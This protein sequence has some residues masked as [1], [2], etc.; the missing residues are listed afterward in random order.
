MS[1]VKSYTDYAS[2]LT[3]A[4]PLFHTWMGIAMLSTALG[5]GC[6]VC[7]WGR[8]VCPNVWIVLLAQSGIL[9]KTT[10][11]NIGEDVLLD[12]GA[13][14]AD[15]IW[16]AEWSFEG[17]LSNMVKRPAGTLIVREFKRFNA[18]L[19]RD[20][21][22]GTKELLVDTYDNPAREARV[23]KTDGEVVVEFPAPSLIGASTIDWFESSLHS[24]DIGGGFLSRMFVIP[25]KH[26][27]EWR[28]LGDSRS[29]ADRLQRQSFAE[30]LKTV[31]Y[32]M[33]GELDISEMQDAF[34]AWLRPYEE[35]W[36]HRC[37]PELVGTVARSGANALKLTAIYQADSGVPSTVLSLDAF[38]RARATVEFANEQMA[39]LLADG[40]GLSKDAK[41]RK[42][43]ADAVKAAYPDPLPHSTALRNLHLDAKA[44][45]RHAKT[46]IESEEIE[47]TS[48]DAAAGKKAAKAYRWVNGA[49]P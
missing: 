37:P 3:D 15:R 17:L 10:S 33:T 18:A 43:L 20:Y 28:G 44:L 12:H 36:L 41:E 24:E 5:N 39:A 8:R 34:N 25:A 27:G 35:S 40:L 9:R 49:A 13:G 31:R 14:C 38:E 2:R 21:S 23:T 22:R 30:Y 26:S 4:P 6:W 42:K 19:G 7:S 45:E 46:L 32:G 47:V 48:I 16:P 29:E 11:L 1:F